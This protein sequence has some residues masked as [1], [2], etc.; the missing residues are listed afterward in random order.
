FY[1]R[2]L[3]DA[4]PI[5][6]LSPS[7]GGGKIFASYLKDATSLVKQFDRNGKLERE[8]EL[9]GVGTASGFGAKKDDKSLYYSFTSYIHPSTIYKY[10]ITSLKSEVYK[11]SCAQFNPEQYESKQIF[12]TTKDG[13]KVP[14]IITHK[15]GVKL[16]G[17]NPTMLYAY[18]GF[19]IS[20]TPAFSLA[21]VILLEQGGVYAVAN[22]RGGGEY[23]DRKSTRLNSSHVKI[24]YA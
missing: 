10:D 22:L 13:T 7:T 20:L 16:D 12:Y 5:Y 1:P 23:G 19:N 6:V 14:M 21:H 4:L 15:K 2:S 9:P 8:I 11:K 17:T 18:G 24:S 3:H